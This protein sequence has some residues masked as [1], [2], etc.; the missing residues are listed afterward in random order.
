MKSPS[1]IG[2]RPANGSDETVNIWYKGRQRTL[3]VQEIRCRLEMFHIEYTL[4]LRNRIL[5]KRWHCGNYVIREAALRKLQTH[6]A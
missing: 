6:V 4:Q 3:C 1:G 5:A 2:I